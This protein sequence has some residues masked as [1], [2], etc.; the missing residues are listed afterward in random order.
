MPTIE[1][2]FEKMIGIEDPIFID[3]MSVNLDDKSVHIELDIHKNSTFTCPICG[4]T[5][6]KV[7]DRIPRAWRHLNIF[8]FETFIHYKVP[9]VTCPVCGTHQTSVS[10][11]SFG[12]GFTLLFEYFAMT[13]GHNMTV[14]ELS[15]F[16]GVPD[17]RIWRI[18]FNYIRTYWEKESWSDVKY[19]GIDETSCKKAIIILQYLLIWIRTEFYL[20]LKVKTPLP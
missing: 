18:F 4:K 6:L 3:S 7:Y 20:L 8:Q 10:W 14:S 1:N 5:E 19:L 15:C 17:P 12:S 13:L 9:R 16:V 11:A 2:L